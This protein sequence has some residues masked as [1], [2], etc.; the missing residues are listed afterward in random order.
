MIIL[1]ILTTSLIHFSWSNVGRMYFLSLGVKGLMGNN[2][3]LLLKNL[4]WK[5]ESSS[6]PLRGGVRGL[7]YGECW[8]GWSAFQ[9]APPHPPSAPP[10][11]LGECWSYLSVDAEPT[12]VCVCVW[13]GGG[14]GGW[15]SGGVFSA[16]SRNC[17]NILC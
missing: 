15:V 8:W 17:V 11:A 6:K 5:L 7:R 12:R 14:G 9:P 1:P 2:R 10:G 16:T 13:G 3:I 4:S